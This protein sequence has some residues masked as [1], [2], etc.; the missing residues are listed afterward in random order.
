M[1]KRNFFDNV[2]KTDSILNFNFKDIEDI[3]TIG[4]TSPCYKQKHFW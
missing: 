2:G 3:V 1:W 4:F